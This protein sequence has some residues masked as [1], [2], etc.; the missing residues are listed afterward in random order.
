MHLCTLIVAQLIRTSTGGKPTILGMRS[1]VSQ[2]LEMLAGGITPE[3]ILKIFVS[4]IS[5]S[6]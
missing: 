5:L 3:E 1:T 2:V 6:N 4:E